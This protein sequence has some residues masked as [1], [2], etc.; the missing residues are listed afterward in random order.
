MDSVADMVG[1]LGGILHLKSEPVLYLASTVAVKMV[2]VLPS[3]V[4]QSHLIDIVHPLSSLLKSPTLQVSL[5]CAISLS[6]IISNISLKIE[7]EVWE[8]LRETKTVANIVCNIKEFY[9]GTKPV[10]YYQE[11]VSL[12][13]NIL[14]RWPSSRFSIWNDIELLDALDLVSVETSISAKISV[15]QLY[16]AIA[17]CGNGA[18]KL[19]ERKACLGLMVHSMGNSDLHSLQMEGF[20]LTECFALTEQGCLTMLNVCCKSLVR[21]TIDA[22]STFSEHSG[23]LSKDHLSLLI[24]ACHMAMIT[25]WAGEHHV[26]F[27]KY[28]IHGII[29]DLLLNNY[30]KKYELQHHLS[31]AEQITIAQEGL[32]TNY[33][34]ILRPY[35]WDIV[36]GLALHGADDLIPN[37]QW[38]KSLVNMIITCACLSFMESIRATRQICQKDIVAT[39][40]N[41]AA[42]RAVLFMIY[43]PC[44]HVASQTKAVLCEMLRPN[45]KEDV[46]Y[47]LNTLNAMTSGDKFK[48]SDNLQMTIIL[49]SLASCSGLAKYQKHIIKNNGIKTLV[50]FLSSQLN[51]PFLIERSSVALHLRNTYTKKAC[52]HVTKGWE[53]QD[54]LLLFGLWALTELLHYLNLQKNNGEVSIGWMDYSESQLVS[55]LKVVLNGSYAPGPKWYAAY[56]LSFFGH[57]GFPNKHGP[58]I[59][60]ALVDSE[61]TDLKLVL[62]NNESVSVHA[63]ILMV[64]CRTLLPHRE[65][66]LD[67]KTSTYSFSEQDKERCE[68]LPVVVRLSA[69]VDCQ[70]LLKLLEYIYSGFLQAGEDLVKKLRIFAKH[71]HLHHL[72]QLLCRRRPRW[73]TPIPIFDLTAALG[74]AGHQISDIVLE[75]KVDELEH[76]SCDICCISR[77]HVHA[78][79]VVVCSSCEYLQALFQSGMQESQSHTIKVP[80]SWKALIKLVHWFYSGELPLPVSGCLWDNLDSDEKLLEM[81][82]Y[83]ELCWLAEFWLLEDLHEKCSRIV[84]SCLDSSRYLSIKILRIAASL[85]QWKLT[86][87]SAE[88]VA[89]LYHRLRISGEL[90]A[91]DEELVDMVRAASVRLSQE[92]SN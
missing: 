9:R 65:R 20:K 73:G 54:M 41:E 32:N 36:G 90:E 59:S 78:H 10:E 84:I 64:R 25:R 40:V 63:V 71:C 34:L 45:G 24:K 52:C 88:Y 38:D 77:P 86:E 60:K 35:I 5:S 28:G 2:N 6:L 62:M 49:I 91:L 11:M 31:I 82:T 75:A 79:K 53:G 44:K 15:L 4:I 33:L 50:S 83:L 85:N 37:A 30:H 70:A 18:K 58:A 55:Q 42:S 81:A 66:P 27:W 43:S 51:R 22:M 26:Y 68:R 48:V 19:L 57:Y 46:K 21:A 74:E 89:P 67:D 8:I 87:V 69:H 16:S 12:L 76:W 56:A 80:I 92:D 13:S 7:S 14:W 1:A 3:S 29:L 17:L 72:L 39:F 47:L 23:K 61:H